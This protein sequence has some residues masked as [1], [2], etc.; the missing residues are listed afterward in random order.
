[1]IILGLNAYHADSSA[2]LIKDGKLIAAAEEERF[3]RIKHW[4][5]FPAESI[6][7][8]LKAGGITAK[9]LDYICINRNIRANLLK[10]I[11]YVVRK[12]P[13]LSSLKDRLH[14]RRKIGNLKQVKQSS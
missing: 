4:S 11:G 2:A 3:N 13:S 10:K 1:M 5:G 9:E 14:N 8:C 6:K 12:L 7:Y